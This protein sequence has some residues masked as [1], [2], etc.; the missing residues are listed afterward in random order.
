MQFFRYAEDRVPVLIVVSY[1]ALNVVV[2]LTVSNPYLLALWTLAG[3]IP[4]G[5]ISA[6]NH[7]H[8]HVFT[9]KQPVLNRLLEI[10]Y[11][12]MTGIIGHGWVLHHVVGH[13]IHYL[14]QAKDESRWKTLSGRRMSE[15]EYIFVTTVTAYPRCLSVGM[16]HPKHLRPFLL[17]GAIILALLGAACY[18]SPLAT[19][20]VWVLPM[21][22]SLTVTVWATYDHH[23]GLETDDHFKASYNI[24]NK[25]YN[26]MTCNLGY[27]TAHHYRQAVHWSRLP[28][29]HK[30]IEDKIGPEFYKNP[31][32]PF[33]WVYAARG[34]FGGRGLPDPVPANVRGREVLAAGSEKLQEA[35]D[36]MLSPLGMD[37]EG[38]KAT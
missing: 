22:I 15:L 3:I 14:D 32:V 34:L 13:H 37:D 10:P 5:W 4:K 2:F 30:E 29:L 1:F 19:L 6:W 38:A 23:S 31:G 20:F 36:S 25:W 18:Y 27:H 26:I 8:Q 24:V 17:N 28:Q 11:G 35:L 9:F 12:L 33:T 21:I 16:K 7:H